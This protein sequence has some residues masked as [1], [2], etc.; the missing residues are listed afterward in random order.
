MHL[1]ASATG[2]RYAKWV[3]KQSIEDAVVKTATS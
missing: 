2:M 1:V 3:D